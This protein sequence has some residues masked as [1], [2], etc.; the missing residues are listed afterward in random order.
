LGTGQVFEAEGT[1]D[2]MGIGEVTVKVKATA[3]PKAGKVWA[4]AVS[5][6]PQ[7]FIRRQPIGIEP[8]N[9][10]IDE[11]SVPYRCDRDGERTRKATALK[12]GDL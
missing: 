1:T 11:P 2:A 9:A 4:M 6:L 5:V 3:M 7:P 8:E 10:P 12:S